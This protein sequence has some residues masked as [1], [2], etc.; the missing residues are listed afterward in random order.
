VKKHPFRK[1]GM[2]VELDGANAPQL[3]EVD[4]AAPNTTLFSGKD[5]G[6]TQLRICTGVTDEV[7]G[8]DLTYQEFRWALG[9]SLKNGEPFLD[10]K[11]ANLPQI[12]KDYAQYIV[13]APVRPDPKSSS[14][15]NVEPTNG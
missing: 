14:G 9:H 5:T 7:W 2:L 6:R 3:V 4:I 10:L 1:Q 15:S 13:G 8:V 11:A 12:K